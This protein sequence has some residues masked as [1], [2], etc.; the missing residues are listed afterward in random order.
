ME[1]ARSESWGATV[2][3]TG[4]PPHRFWFNINASKAGFSSTAPWI[5]YCS[6]WR[7]ECESC[8]KG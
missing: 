1:P 2:L 8:H 3:C 7:E 4:E 5:L 6:A